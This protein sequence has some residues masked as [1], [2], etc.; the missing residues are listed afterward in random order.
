MNLIDSNLVKSRNTEIDILRFVGIVMIILAHVQPPYAIKEIRSFDVP[1]MLFVSGLAY[2]NKKPDFSLK[3]LWKR[4]KRLVLPIWIF[5]SAY[6]LMAFTL[7]Y[8]VGIDFGISSRQ[9]FESY[10]FLEGIGFVWII[11]VFLL[12]SILT[13][14][15]IWLNGK[16]NNIHFACFITLW[17]VAQDYICPIPFCQNNFIISQY[18]LYAS[19]YS[20]SFIFGLRA[21]KWDTNQKL[22]ALALAIIALLAIIPII[23]NDILPLPCINSFKYPPRTFYLLYGIVLSLFLYI[24]VKYMSN[25]STIRLGGVNNILLFI[26]QNTIW[27]YLY[28]IPLVQITGRF[29][30]NWGIRYFIVLFLAV[31]LTYL[32]VRLSYKSEKSFA[33][34]FLG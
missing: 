9:V 24:A 17:F 20:I 7:K 8:T 27:I 10:L 25:S 12:I 29:G 33:K 15:L 18:I 14:V 28:H 2:G 4:C 3:N 22:R 26:G 34:Y 11:R 6:F 16:L 5:L 31:V 1:L 19:G 30:M 32:Q 21:A 13:P 23:N